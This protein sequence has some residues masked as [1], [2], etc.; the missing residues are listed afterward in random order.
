MA[1]MLGRLVGGGVLRGRNVARDHFPGPLLGKVRLVMLLTGVG[2]DSPACSV[3]RKTCLGFR[4]VLAPE[5]RDLT[6][7]CG[8]VKPRLFMGEPPL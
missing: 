1:A 3:G 4:E 2:Q 8:G 6:A 5:A 7:A